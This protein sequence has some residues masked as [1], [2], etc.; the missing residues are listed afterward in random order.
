MS[1]DPRGRWFRVYSR[2]V[3]QHPKFRD[4]NATELGVW[5][6]LRAEA[7]LRTE[8][9]FADET[10]ALFI[11]RRRR[12]PK[13]V[14]MLERMIELRLFDRHDD[15]SIAVH[16]R[17]EN[18]R[19]TYPSDD[20]EET[21]KRKAAER[22]RKAS[23]KEPTRDSDPSRTASRGVTNGHE[24]RA[25]APSQPASS[26]Q[27][28]TNSRQPADAQAGEPIINDLPDASDPVT[29]ACR[30]LP[31][32]GEWL[33][34]D[35]YR[36]AW[37][38]LVRRFGK[39]WVLEAIPKGYQD[40]IKRGKVRPWD[41][42]RFTEWHLAQRN[43]ADELAEEKARA[44]QIAAEAE[45][46]RRAIEEATPEDRERAKLQKK[47]IRLGLELGLDVPTDPEEVRKFVMKH[48]S[49]A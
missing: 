23:E 7:D 45:A 33:S 25:H 18:D 24:P 9:A 37:T 36:V 19:Q 30:Y 3:R 8:A 22:E 42:K 47:A 5:M 43:R 17:E 1:A 12:T 49:A 44:D 21:R 13:P 32:G 10:E 27:P 48:G 26:P 16:D 11:L 4:L 39:E 28:S 29:E 34:D 15:G 41:L 6:A 35:D 2:Q 14:V 40:C 31:N 46:H 38:D 20:P